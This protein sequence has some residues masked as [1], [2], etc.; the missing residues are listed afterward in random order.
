MTELTIHAVARMF[1]K[2]LEA[3]GRRSFCPIRAHRREDKSFSIFRASDG[4]WLWKCHCC[5][6]GVNAGD[7]LKLYC[8]RSGRDRREAWRELKE[9]GYAVPGAT[10][11]PR[12]SYRRE[13]PPRRV[14]APIEGR[15]LSPRIIDLPEKRWQELSSA[16]L[17]AVERFAALRGLDPEVC[18]LLDVVDVA[19]DAIGFGYRDPETQKPCRVKV[20]A[21]GKKAF[22]IEPRATD[23]EQGIALSPLYLA[24]GL[25][26]TLGIEPVVTLVEGEV[27]ALTLRSVGIRNVVSL[28]DGAG[29]GSRVDLKPLWS[30]S[31]LILSAVDADEEGEKAHRD[32][33]L[34]F[35]GMRKEVARVRWQLDGGTVYKDAN[36]ARMAGW[37][38]EQFAAC[39]QYAANQ[40]RGYDV[41]LATAC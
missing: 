34:R 13:E 3:P 21:L 2:S 15:K 36:E 27:D 16:R 40:L 23:G 33:Y 1:G 8:M 26:R 29:S 4:K 25:D 5:D 41:N 37:G 9:Q 14:V 35:H 31:S 32:I 24:H 22:W 7:A 20:R 12:A 17:G 19:R 10:D 28:P 11:E 38:K 30:C 18:R 6:S 39:M